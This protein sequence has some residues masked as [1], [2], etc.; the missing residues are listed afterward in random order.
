MRVSELTADLQALRERLAAELAAVNAYEP[1]IEHVA[2]DEARAVVKRLAD[3]HKEHVA[4][5]AG[6]IES[7]AP[8]PAEAG[9]A[10]RDA[11]GS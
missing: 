6:A 9:R 5:L 3:A 10:A 7:L 8:R 1:L 4:L 2:H 11:A